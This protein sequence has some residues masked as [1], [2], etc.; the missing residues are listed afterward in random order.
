M[1]EESDFFRQDINGVPL[2]D[3]VFDY[4]K[5]DTNLGID[6]DETLAK[7]VER[8]YIEN[9]NL[10]EDVKNALLTYRQDWFENHPIVETEDE[11][12]KT[13]KTYPDEVFFRLYNA[14]GQDEFIECLKNANYFELAKLR[15]KDSKTQENAEEYR[16]FLQRP[17]EYMKQIGKDVVSRDLIQDIFQILSSEQA[18]ELGINTKRYQLT[19]NQLFESAIVATIQ[20]GIRGEEMQT[21]VDTIIRETP[22]GDLTSTISESPGYEEPT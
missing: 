12:S 13:S 8:I 6:V 4:F 9:A 22:R 19:Q 18:Q 7:S 20:E 21:A 3:V 1:Q 15:I 10:S 16:E 11:E 2:L 5:M 17:A 14:M